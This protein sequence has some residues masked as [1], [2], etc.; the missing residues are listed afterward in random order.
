MEKPQREILIEFI[1]LDIYAG[2]TD[3]SFEENLAYLES[4]TDEQLYE[5][6]NADRP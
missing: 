1:M 6:I 5:I 3:K 4:L 2:N